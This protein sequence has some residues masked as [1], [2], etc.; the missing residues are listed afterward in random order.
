[1]QNNAE[2]ARIKVSIYRVNG[3]VILQDMPLTAFNVDFEDE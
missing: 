3:E 2:G 1:M